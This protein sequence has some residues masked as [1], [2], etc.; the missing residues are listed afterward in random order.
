MILIDSS[1]WIN[2]FRHGN[3][4]LASL[5]Q[6]VEVLTHSFVI[7]ELA[8]GYLKNRKE[9][10]ALLKELPAAAVAEH[11]E[12]L[13]L[14]ETRKLMGQGI[15]WVDAHLIASALLSG[16]PLWTEDRKLRSLSAAMGILF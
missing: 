6:K 4:E 12:V 2:H 5:L 7:G 1:I 8:C 14:V 15:G 13:E 3:A 11:E 10:L 16:A 9:I